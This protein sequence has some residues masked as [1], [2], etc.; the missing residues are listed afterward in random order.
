MVND[1]DLIN[2]IKQ[3]IRTWIS[4]KYYLLNEYQKA[5]EVLNV[6]NY[7]VESS[8]DI[9]AWKGA[10]FTENKISL[11]LMCFVHHLKV[12]LL[13]YPSRVAIKFKYKSF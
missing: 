7:P 8:F 10:W 6:F 13:A 12:A 4:D 1:A 9:S 11:I 3:E 2:I 5:F